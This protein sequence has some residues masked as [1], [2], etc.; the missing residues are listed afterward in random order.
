MGSCFC[1]NPRQSVSRSST[2]WT[3]TERTENVNKLLRPR[4]CRMSVRKTN[5]S[6][7]VY[8]CLNTFL[9]SLIDDKPCICV[10]VCVSAQDPGTCV[11]TSHPHILYGRCLARFDTLKAAHVPRRNFRLEKIFPVKPFRMFFGIF[12]KFVN[13]KKVF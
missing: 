12:S 7:C 13:K 3:T 5:V 8:N 10:V 11:C 2:S 1:S 4:P 6:G 9:L